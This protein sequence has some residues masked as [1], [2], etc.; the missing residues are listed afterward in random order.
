[1]STFDLNTGATAPLA[2][3]AD[4]ADLPVDGALPPGLDGV[5]VRNGPNPLRGR[6]EGNDV[7]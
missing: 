5:L 3:E 2:D 7:L 4:L 1:M 6:F